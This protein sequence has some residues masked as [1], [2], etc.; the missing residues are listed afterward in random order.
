MLN[1]LLRA[2][3]G[4]LSSAQPL[5]LGAR[6]PAVQAT[7]QNGQPVALAELYQ[8]GYVLVFF[9]PKA[10]TP[11][12]TAEACSLRDAFAD[13][14]KLNLT[15]LGVSHDSVATQKAF[16]TEQKL[17][18]D[19]LADPHS[20]LYNAFGVP[21][22]TRQSFLMKNGEVIWR[23]L[24]ASTDHQAADVKKALDADRAKQAPSEYS[25]KDA[26]PPGFDNRPGLS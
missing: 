17:P 26:P 21:G 15:I 7:N 11:G 5:A 14:T 2:V 3:T 6:A 1:F 8:K 22:L 16:A 12:C 9:Y 18:F 4:P 24:S 19:L 20:E 13:L 25:R 10:F 23:A